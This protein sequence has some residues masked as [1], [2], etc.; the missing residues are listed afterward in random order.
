MPI[1]GLG[2]SQEPRIRPSTMFPVLDWIMLPGCFYIPVKRM[3][4]QL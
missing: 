4:E 3:L 1:G 2:T